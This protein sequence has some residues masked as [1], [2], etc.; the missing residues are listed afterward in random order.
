MLMA[1]YVLILLKVLLNVMYLKYSL[2]IL[3]SFY[4]TLFY[5][6]TYN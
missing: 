4:K 6:G 3:Y 1:L 2:I 5:I